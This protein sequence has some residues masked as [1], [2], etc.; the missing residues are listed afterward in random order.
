M[1]VKAAL[2]LWSFVKGVEEMARKFGH[3][4]V[5]QCMKYPSSLLHS[6]A[7]KR[8]GGFSKSHVELIHSTSL[9]DRGGRSLEHT[10][11]SI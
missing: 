11:A 4:A 6:S 7:S 9:P 2:V 1:D 5:G 8:N 3:Y 10:C